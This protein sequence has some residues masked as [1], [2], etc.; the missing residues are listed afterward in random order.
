LKPEI[1][2]F[3]TGVFKNKR[4]PVNL[5]DWEQALERWLKDGVSRELGAEEKAELENEIHHQESRHDRRYKTGVFWEKYGRTVLLAGAASAAAVIVIVLMIA[6]YLEPRRTAGM[7]PLA[8]VQTYYQSINTLDPELMQDCL[9]D[10]A[11][12]DEQGRTDI[13]FVTTKQNFYIAGTDD[14]FRADLW[15][16][17][18]RPR[19]DPP[20]F[21]DGVAALSITKERGEPS[22]VFIADYERWLVEPDPNNTARSGAMIQKGVRSK[23]RVTLSRDNQGWRISKLERLEQTPI[24]SNNQGYI[25]KEPAP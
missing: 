10:G 23:E 21:I 8:V 18:G 17:A 2:T 13:M 25:P 3:L 12:S 22:P 11:A 16:K 15:E 24:Y 1:S 19:V 4:L 5:S 20:R 14:R 9:Q 6:H 7:T